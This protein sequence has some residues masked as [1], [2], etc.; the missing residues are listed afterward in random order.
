MLCSPMVAPRIAES[1]ACTVPAVSAELSR[2]MK[3]SHAMTKATARGADDPTVHPVQIASAADVV[4]ATV[5]MRLH[6]P[7]SR[8]RKRQQH[9]RP[10]DWNMRFNDR[11]PV[12]RN[13]E[14]VRDRVC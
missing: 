2:K 13:P 6:G 12:A 11:P 9:H 7:G 3:A 10:V 1:E 14:V 4:M 5:T 8:K